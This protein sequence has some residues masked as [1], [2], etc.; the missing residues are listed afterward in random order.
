MHPQRR[1]EFTEQPVFASLRNRMSR[2]DKVC[3]NLCSFC[4]QIDSRNSQ[5]KTR[6]HTHD[7]HWD[8]KGNVRNLCFLLAWHCT[9]HAFAGCV[10]ALP[11][12]IIP[13]SE[14]VAKLPSSVPAHAGVWRVGLRAWH[15]A[16]GC[17][18]TLVAFCLRGS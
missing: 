3:Y 4:E 5:S 17:L 11:R 8:I 18:P 10:K 14:R 1:M 12:A 6:M 13:N 16:L 9:S 2:S 15:A 7:L